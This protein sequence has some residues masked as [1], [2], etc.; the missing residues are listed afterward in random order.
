MHSISLAFLDLWCAGFFFFM[1]VFLDR[2][3]EHMQV[4]GWVGEGIGGERES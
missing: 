3:R 2:E 1:F 4:G